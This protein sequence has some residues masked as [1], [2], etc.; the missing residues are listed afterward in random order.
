MIRFTCTCADGGVVC[1]CR[2]DFPCESVHVLSDHSEEVWF[3][4]FSHNGSML[5]SGSKDGLIIIWNTAVSLSCESVLQN[6]VLTPSK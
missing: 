5:A 1:P 6:S 2:A 4:K 3:V